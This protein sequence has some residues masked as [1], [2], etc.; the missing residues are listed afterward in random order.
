VALRRR[1]VL[2]ALGILVALV[3]IP[4]PFFFRFYRMPSG[5]MQPTLVDGDR[6]VIRL[7]HTMPSR[8]DV[9][10]FDFPEDPSKQFVKRVIGVGG[11]SVRLRDDGVEVNGTLIAREKLGPLRYVDHSDAGLT[12]ERQGQAYRETLD[13]KSWRVI[14][15]PL[16][17]THGCWGAVRFGCEG[18]VKVPDGNVFVLGDNRDNSHD[19]RFWGFVP[20][21]AIH[22]RVFWMPSHP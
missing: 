11:D 10:V 5:S 9:I 13:G 14:E 17:H 20:V 19:S 3:A 6:F 12:L 21:A 4:I 18:P 1:H 7:T 16:L 15:D 8:G 22:G 2:G